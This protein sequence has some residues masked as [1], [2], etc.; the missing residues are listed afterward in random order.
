MVASCTFVHTSLRS[1]SLVVLIPIDEEAGQ[2]WGPLAVI[3]SLAIVY[4]G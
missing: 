1:Y 2:C 4:T 3:L